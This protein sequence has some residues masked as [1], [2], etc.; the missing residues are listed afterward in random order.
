MRT[1]TLLSLSLLLVSVTA[2]EKNIR[3]VRRTEPGP[4]APGGVTVSGSTINV[5]AGPKGNA[6]GIN[7]APRSP[8]DRR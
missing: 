4:V 7:A 8:T 6:V 1:L 2:C 5:R 3:E